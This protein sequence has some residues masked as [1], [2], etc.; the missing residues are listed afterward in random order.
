MEVP[1]D[2]FVKMHNFDAPG[3]AC[4]AQLL[5]SLDEFLS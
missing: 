2:T 5:L 4:S 1:E 3:E